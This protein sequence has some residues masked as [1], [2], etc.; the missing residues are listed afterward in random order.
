MNDSVVAD[1]VSGVVCPTGVVVELANQDII[2]INLAI[3]SLSFKLVT[4]EGFQLSFQ[5]VSVQILGDDVTFNNFLGQNTIKILN[6]GIRRSEDSKWA[7]PPKNLGAF[8][9]VDGGLESIKVVVFLDIR[10]L[11]VLQNRKVT[12]T[13]AGAFHVPKGAQ[14]LLVAMV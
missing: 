2:H 13:D 9:L 3:F 14:D 12:V 7:V 8:G 5:L 10:G 1:G 11:S 6:G 4:I